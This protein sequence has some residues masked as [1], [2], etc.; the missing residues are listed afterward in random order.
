MN[1]SDNQWSSFEDQFFS[2]PKPQ[3]TKNPLDLRRLAAQV[4]HASLREKKDIQEL[5]LPT[6]MKDYL[7]IVIR[8]A[9][10]Q[11]LCMYHKS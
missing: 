7:D 6:S 5:P 8:T 9:P 2:P 1:G 11:Y 3:R 4:I 10:D